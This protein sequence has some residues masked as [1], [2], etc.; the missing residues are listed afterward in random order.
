MKLQRAQVTAF[1]RFQNLSLDFA[2]GLNVIY[3]HNEAGKST[4][5]HFLRGMLFGLQKPGAQKRLPLPELDRLKPWNGTAPRG[6][7]TYENRDGRTYRVERDFSDRGFIRVYDA[8]TGKELTA[9]YK[10]DRRKELLFAEEQLGLTDGAFAATACIGQM[11]ATKLGVTQELTTLLANLVS[12]GQEDVSVTGVLRLLDQEMAKIGDPKRDSGKPLAEA[13]RRARDLE[14]DLAHG[15]A[16]QQ[17]NMENERRLTDLRRQTGR[18]AAAAAE[19]SRALSARR[20]QEAAQR[21][22]KLR[23]RRQALAE[24]EAAVAALQTAAGFPVAQRDQVIGLAE[25]VQRLEREGRDA[26]AALGRAHE[27]RL[28][29]ESRLDAFALLLDWG[30]DTEVQVNADF[31]QY[32]VWQQDLRSREANLARVQAELADLTER[33]AGFGD[34]PTAGAALEARLDE[35]AEQAQQVESEQTRLSQSKPALL[36]QQVRAARAVSLR[37]GIAI[38]AAVALA[39]VSAILALSLRQPVLAGIALLAVPLWF[40]LRPGQAARQ[41]AAAAAQALAAWEE[42]ARQAASALAAA[43]AGKVEILAQAGCTTAAEWKARRRACGSL[44]QERETTR[45]E[46]TNLAAERQHIEQSLSVT[47]EALAQV[48]AS[49]QQAAAGL[50]GGAGANTA[51]AP[52]LAVPGPLAITDE[53]LRQFRQVWAAYRRAR[54]A[55][56]EAG[57]QEAQAQQRLAR[58]GEELAAGQRSLAEC[59]TAAGAA[60]L[61]QYNAAH[62]RYLSY[63]E[64]V[65][66]QSTAAAVLQQALAE[67]DEASLEALLAELA[68]AAAEAAGPGSAAEAAAPGDAQEIARRLDAAK[69][70]LARNQAEVRGLEERLEQAYRDLPDLAGLETVVAEARSEKAALEERRWVLGQA[71]AAIEA[72]SE[73]VHREFAPRLNQVAS[74]AIASITA[75][76]YSEVRVDQYLGLRVVVPETG[77]MQPVQNLSGGAVDQFYLALR[78]GMAKLLTAGGEPVPFLLDDTFVQFDDE[79][80]ARAMA[81][82]TEVAAA[83]QVFLFTCHE[84]E[85]AA[86]RRCQPEARVLELSAL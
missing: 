68:P 78:L 86:A 36:E 3:G 52:A 56:D 35:L 42:E 61:T 55:A 76:R 38:G 32:S 1:G 69:A 10:P 82:L 53:H 25:A 80:L 64:A 16:V 43:R 4:L 73:E 62:Q 54:E 28:Q 11:E 30:P 83:N 8:A 20:Y 23:Q 77:E 26:R 21:L 2:P 7:L 12:G 85:V 15:R 79:R 74:A 67:G 50:A 75:G 51:A 84:R 19:L 29:T 60:D 14:A 49:I 5:L 18:L 44:E 39:L 70:E 41:A 6:T 31:R 63:R 48:V 66:N 71:K 27:E 58:A 45:R 24:Q 57:R 59:L 81:H 9:Q 17:E 13:G 22:A 34:L 37:Q 65:T 46:A 72:A 47:G 33:I 40:G